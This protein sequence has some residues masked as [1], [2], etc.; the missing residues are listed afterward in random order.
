FDQFPE[1][2]YVET[3]L[4]TEAADLALP[5]HVR[6]SGLFE[7]QPDADM[8][9]QIRVLN[10]TA[11]VWQ[12]AKDASYAGTVGKPKLFSGLPEGSYMLSVPMY[13]GEGGI[14]SAGAFPGYSARFNWVLL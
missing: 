6:K 14:R 9:Y 13:R 5:F 3:P 8:G 10:A 7:T 1:G 2:S 11:T 12:D 4:V